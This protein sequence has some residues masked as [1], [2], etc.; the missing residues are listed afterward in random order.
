MLIDLIYFL[1]SL[2]IYF[3]LCLFLFMA[4]YYSIY[5]TCYIDNNKKPFDRLLNDANGWTTREIFNSPNEEDKRLFTFN[6]MEDYENR[7]F[8]LEQK[9]EVMESETSVLKYR[10]LRYCSNKR[11]R[12]IIQ[13][14]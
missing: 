8:V 4:N 6:I 7:L 14:I 10:Q 12:F 5:Y 3:P 1:F 9:V 13:L 2:L 11:F